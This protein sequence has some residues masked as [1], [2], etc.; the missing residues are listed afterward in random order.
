MSDKRCVELFIVDVFVAIWKIK[1]YTKGISS[2]DNLLHDEIRW[3]ATIRNLE[4]IGE[5]TN[6]ILKDDRFAQLS[7][8]YFRKVVNFRNMIS[9]G[10]FGISQEEVWNI[11]TEKLDI[12]ES[13]MKKIAL[14][15]YNLTEAIGEEL[16]KQMS[17]EVQTLLLQLKIDLHKRN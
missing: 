16:P 8:K 3:D 7:P 13:D 6:N 5:A 2:A 11:I 10:Y 9:H 15:H 14:E 17:A 1:L 12:L 4:I